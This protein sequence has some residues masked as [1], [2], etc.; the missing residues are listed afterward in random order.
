MPCSKVEEDRTYP[1][2]FVALLNLT[3]FTGKFYVSCGCLLGTFYPF[4]LR[5]L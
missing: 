5:F 4:I 1:L 3:F 2:V